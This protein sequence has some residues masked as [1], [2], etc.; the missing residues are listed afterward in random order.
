MSDIRRQKEVNMEKVYKR[1]NGTIIVTLPRSC[2]REKL[3]KVTEEFLIK[4]ISGGKK[5]VNSNTSR[6][7]GKK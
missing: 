5:N 4:V 6:N 1:K 3:R 2:D 7:L